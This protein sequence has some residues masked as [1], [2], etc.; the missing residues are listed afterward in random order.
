MEITDIIAKTQKPKLYEKGSAVM[1]TDPYISQKVLQIHLHPEID[2]GSRKHSTIKSTV[3]WVLSKT[4]KQQMNILD[5][6]CGPGLYTEI[7][8]RK[9]HKVT[10]VDFSE[11]SI[12][13][14]KQEAEK[15]GLDISY[16]HQ[17]YLELDVPDSSFDLVTLIYTDLGVLNP[18][19]RNILLENIKKALKPD[20]IFI[21]DVL[22]DKD[23]DKKVSP[24]NWEVADGGFWRANPYLAISESILYEN[25]KVVLS[26]HVIA[27]DDRVEVYRFWT[28]F[29]SHKDIS[30]ML[31][32]YGFSS[33]SFH[34]DVLPVGDI[35]NGDNVTFCVANKL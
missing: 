28:H 21:F 23:L 4:S 22:N 18:D 27:E 26:Q 2:L 3:E 1:W 32:P 15:N 12:N 35:W 19:E 17:N 34:E 6:G 9:G 8:A 33:M 29:F 20:G 25:E 14:A 11:N 31:S 30:G 10:G 7:F 13:Y 5:L 16:L 24:K